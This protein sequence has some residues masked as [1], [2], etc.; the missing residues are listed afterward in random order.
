MRIQPDEAGGAV[1]E[2]R[3]AVNMLVH[4]PRQAQ[5]IA[6]DAHQGGV[7]EGF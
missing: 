3:S 1:F 2:N 6:S 4:D 5:K 7:I